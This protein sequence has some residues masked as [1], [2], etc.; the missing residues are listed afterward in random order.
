M[1]TEGYDP[2]A[3]F[4]SGEVDDLSTLTALNEE[5]LL[6][7]LRVRYQQNRIYTFVG[8]I[9]VAVNPYNR[10]P[11]YGEQQIAAYN[12]K[13]RGE[14][15]PHVY[16]IADA[17]YYNLFN[18]R[19]NQCA[20]ISGESGAG[21][22]ESAK[23]I[24]NYV[25]ERCKAGSYGTSLEEQI[26]KISPV[27]EAF[28]NA[29]TNM[30]R[31]SSRF[32]KYTR[33][34]FDAQ[35]A[36]VGVQLSE[37]LL[38]KARVVKQLPGERNFHVFYY[39]FAHPDVASFGLDDPS[40]FSIL[41][42]APW[43]DNGAMFAELQDALAVVGF[44]SEQFDSVY[45]TLA[46]CVHL[47]NVDF[48]A[49]GERAAIKDAAPIE[50]A[51]RLLRTNAENLGSSLLGVNTVTRGEQIRCFNSAEQA[52]ESR[53]SLIKA[54]YGSLFGWIVNAVNEM[55]APELHQKKIAGGRPGMTQRVAPKHEI[56]VLDIFG[57]E[58]FQT[59]SFEQICINVAHEQLQY[60][61]NRY[62]FLVELE[63]YEREGIDAKKVSFRDNAAL[64]DAFL[65]RPVGILSLLDEESSFPKATDQTFAE[66]IAHN[67]G[68]KPFFVD[69]QRQRE[70]P[71]FAI[72]HFA[73]EIEYNCT[74]ILMKNRDQLGGDIV[75]V[76]R[77]SDISVISD[78]FWGEITNTGQI[79]P[80]A[81][82]GLGTRQ[83]RGK[84]AAA[85]KAD[86]NKVNRKTPSLSTQFRNSLAV[87]LDRMKA[88]YPHFVRCIKP[89]GAQ[90]MMNF[91]D[92]M[93]RT[94]LSYTG[95]LE[96]TRIRREGY[97]WRPT[98]AEFVSRYKSV[99]FP[100]TKLNQVQANARAAR[101]ILETVDAQNWQIGKTKL[102][103]RFYHLAEMEAALVNFEKR[104][105][106]AQTAI[107]GLLARRL[108]ATLEARAVM[109]AAERAEAEARDVEVR[110]RM[111][112]ERLRLQ[113]IED[114]RQQE[115]EMRMLELQKIEMDLV[116]AEARAADELRVAKDEEA[117]RAAA[118][119]ERLMVFAVAS[120]Q[121][122]AI[123][124]ARQAQHHAEDLACEAR[125]QQEEASRLAF[126]AQ[127][128]AAETE[129]EMEKLAEFAD[130]ARKAKEDAEKAA[131]HA[132]I[133]RQKS[134]KKRKDDSERQA[135]EARLRA[136]A[137]AI[138]AEQARKAQQ[139]AEAEA[140][141][142]EE[143]R[144]MRERKM[145]EDQEHDLEE[146]LKKLEEEAQVARELAQAQAKAATEA[147]L[148]R[149]KA[150]EIAR[151]TEQERMEE[152][153]RLQEEKAAEEAELRAGDY[154]LPEF[155][156]VSRVE[157]L[158]GT[159]PNDV[160]IHARMAKGFL[161]KVGGGRK[162]WK[163]RWFMADFTLQ[164]LTLNYY[165]SEK[166]KKP[167]GVIP[168]KDILRSFASNSSDP[169]D[170]NLFMVETLSRTYFLHAPSENA[171]RAWIT[172]L[173]IVPMND[174]RDEV[175]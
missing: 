115:E 24:I 47:G 168:L 46:A 173:N 124:E 153:L 75:D 10:L 109:N 53:N 60:F 97:A 64:I 138:V 96:A 172:I 21:K 148:A 18:M 111:E 101:K 150:N 120:E 74:S 59:N 32:G 20:V 105:V 68:D 80:R 37:Y 77:A 25:I 143:E 58:N 35:G 6:S 70:Y 19:K 175:A 116:E 28:G 93:V 142:A 12:K 118:E 71:A 45:N 55:L 17:C 48:I 110:Q 154:T 4:E 42:G 16:T 169:K 136:E 9:L 41:G 122:E 82:D 87:L 56:G 112:E 99:A 125:R 164:D 88:C 54:F 13:K 89:N 162:T 107:R 171:M 134:R 121:I 51:A 44:T 147:Q 159:M 102:F 126:E 140:K 15:P 73:A 67:Y 78:L 155:N 76:L 11:I 69:L 33:L 119:A 79:R 40:K 166:S 39:L 81:S 157:Q 63:E 170:Q 1:A 50:Q 7:E 72:K 165:E 83:H 141:A 113:A 132:R 2:M 86:S 57:F 98:F 49:Q 30:N 62:T 90:A 38:E 65:G 152:E 36:V 5:I 84:D 103:L 139:K 137:E 108:R 167:K 106:M 131:T 146:Q 91:Q 163:K 133:E 22:T 144:K 92:D 31:N 3:T 114:Q 61:F 14:M 95:V 85:G 8:D 34:L 66:K 128:L 29:Q 145:R 23:L 52:L 160:S 100:I 127:Q 151:R 117:L 27:L 43:E 123:N 104:I 135:E 26:V 158:I 156:L 149:E 161:M 129:A 174:N 94:Q 130:A